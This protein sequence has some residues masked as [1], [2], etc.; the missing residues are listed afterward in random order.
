MKLKRQ[1][2]I[3]KTY[4]EYYMCV[5]VDNLIVISIDFF[6]VMAQNLAL[7]VNTTEINGSR[8]YTKELVYCCLKT[9]M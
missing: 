9:A 2:D 7:E 1:N 5:L 3:I 4:Y 6:C 8:H